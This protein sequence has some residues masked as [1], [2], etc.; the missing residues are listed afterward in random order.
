MYK[1]PDKRICFFGRLDGREMSPRALVAELEKVSCG[2]NC[3]DYSSDIVLEELPRHCSHTPQNW[4]LVGLML[5]H[6]F[7]RIPHQGIQYE[8]AERLRTTVKWHA[9]SLV[10]PST[11]SDEV[12]LLCAKFPIHRIEKN[13]GQFPAVVRGEYSITSLHRRLFPDWPIVIDK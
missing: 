3:H 12:A 6:L 9:V 11:L 13:R 8:R 4:A 7:S 10:D 1:F 2:Y 5:C